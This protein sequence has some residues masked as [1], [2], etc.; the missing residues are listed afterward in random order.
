[1]PFTFSHPAA[2]L[3]FNIV[4][5]RWF[6]LTALFIGSL[7]PDFEYFLRM[8]MYGN[9]SHTLEGVFVFNLPLVIV[10]SFLYHL[11][12]RDSLINNLPSVF[13]KR[14]S[15]YTQFNWVAYFKSHFF[16]V[17][18]SALIGIATHILWD[19]FTHSSGFAV[20]YI[21][22]LRGS[23]SVGGVRLKVFNVLQHLSSFLG[24]AI[25]LYWVYKMP[26]TAPFKNKISAK[27]WLLVAFACIAV[28]LARYYLGDDMT[29][30][31][32]WIVPLISSTMAAVVIAS[33]VDKYIY[34]FSSKQKAL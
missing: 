31:K 21:G 27:Y 12:V 28:F 1:M 8:E 4:K 13:Y 5:P 24:F 16:I 22:V 9:Y 25:L 10:L 18:V 30:L 20:D 11:I 34:S 26:A 33:L 6:S 29:S 23:F 15:V 14:L 19:G 7:A 2:I 3:P 32:K 17:V